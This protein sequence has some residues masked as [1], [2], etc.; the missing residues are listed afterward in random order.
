[1]KKLAVLGAG[2]LV[3]LPCCAIPASAEEQSAIISAEV[4]ETHSLTV[5]SSQEIDVYLNRKYRMTNG[6]TVSLERLSAP[7]L[8][9]LLKH[10]QNISKAY[11]N[12]VD[13]TDQIKHEKYGFVASYDV[14]SVYQDYQLDLEIHEDLPQTGYFGT[15]G[16]IEIA[17]AVLTGA[18][19]V[20]VC[21]A[22][23]RKETR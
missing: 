20:F 18:G 15:E 2:L 19:V 4:P 17:A 6:E 3:L 23:R 14:P 16:L 5:S 13:I 21:K 7:H 1:M 22:R 9:F 10:E 12:G 8:M 11:L